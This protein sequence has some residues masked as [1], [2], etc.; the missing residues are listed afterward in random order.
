M[1]GF[2]GDELV[3]N[4]TMQDWRTHNGLDIR[5]SMNM[6]VQAPANGTV[7]A[8]YEDPQWGGVVEIECQDVMVRLCG[9]DRIKCKAGDTVEMGKTIALLGDIPAERH[10]VPSACGVHKRRKTGGPRKLFL[11]RFL[12]ASFPKRGSFCRKFSQM[13]TA[14][15][16]RFSLKKEGR[17]AIMIQYLNWKEGRSHM[18][19]FHF[20]PTETEGVFIIEPSVFGD[21]RGY[22]METYQ[23]EEFAAAGI[24]GPF[25]QDNQSKSTKGV[26]RGLHFQKEHTQGKLVRVVSGEVFDVAV[27]CRPKSKTFRKMGGRG[28]SAEN[29]KQF[30]IPQGFAHGFLVLSDEAEFTYKCTDYYDPT[31]EGRHPLG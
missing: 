28:L 6:G 18:G 17:H 1:Q 10:G 29:K 24:P 9:L 19:K 22:F 15:A 23:Q 8:V 14:W 2:S 12:R 21:A 27:D 30:Y 3:Y 26:L 4:E 16:G 20:V 25:V 31:S 11:K 13:Q 5:G 7:T